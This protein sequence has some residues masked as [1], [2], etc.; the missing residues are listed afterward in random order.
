MRKEE[1]HRKLA[2]PP[3]S[4]RKF[5][6]IELYSPRYIIKQSYNYNVTQFYNVLPN[7]L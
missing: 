1:A 3:V 4:V 5:I 7:K 2:N 6:L